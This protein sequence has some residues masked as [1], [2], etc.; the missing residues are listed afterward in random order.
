MSGINRTSIQNILKKNKFYPY[1]IRLVHEL[2]GDDCERR[3]QFCEIMSEQAGYDPQFL[4]NI[5]VS[6]ECSFFLYGKIN[7]YTCRYWCDSNPRVFYEV[8]T[9]QPKKSNL[10]LDICG[11]RLVGSF[12]LPGNLSGEMYLQLLEDAIYPALT[13]KIIHSMTKMI[14]IFNR[15]VPLHIIRRLLVII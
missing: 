14:F 6:D 9:H 12:F 8:D 1:K 3:F 4:F 11:D 10:W 13:D 5:C 15:T 2:N 7:R